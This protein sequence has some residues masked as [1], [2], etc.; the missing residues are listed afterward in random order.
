MDLL[1][2]LVGRL[3]VTGRI[4]NPLGVDVGVQVEVQL[5][6]DY[7]EQPRIAVELLPLGR[8]IGAVAAV[9]RKVRRRV[10]QEQLLVWLR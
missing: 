7:F 10:F 4:Q 5:A 3:D 9:L 1:P 2:V 6:I 8:S